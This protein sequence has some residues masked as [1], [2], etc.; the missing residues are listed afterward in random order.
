MGAALAFTTE[1]GVAL[2]ED[3]VDTSCS[4]PSYRVDKY[5]YIYIYIIVV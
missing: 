4:S 2:H 1:G 5:T 3:G